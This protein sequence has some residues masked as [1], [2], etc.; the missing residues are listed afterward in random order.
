M[1]LLKRAAFQAVVDISCA[2]SAWKAFKSL[3]TFLNVTFFASR[4]KRRDLLKAV[5]QRTMILQDFSLVIYLVLDQSN[6]ILGLTVCFVSNIFHRATMLQTSFAL[7]VVGVFEKPVPS[8]RPSHEHLSCIYSQACRL[9]SASLTALSECGEATRDAFALA[10]D[11]NFTAGLWA[12]CARA[13]TASVG[14]VGEKQSHQVAVCPAASGQQAAAVFERRPAAWR[15]PMLLMPPTPA[16]TCVL[17][18]TQHC[19]S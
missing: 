12:L 15:A 3:S 19:F 14:G 10:F 9:L 18:L 13:R 11:H 7:A 8:A 16:R 1:T 5:Q 6:T 4:Q 17:A 2:V